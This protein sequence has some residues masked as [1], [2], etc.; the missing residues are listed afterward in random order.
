ME[1][2]EGNVRNERPRAMK[3]RARNQKGHHPV[4][5]SLSKD[6]RDAQRKKR[7]T[8][9]VWLKPGGR[10]RWVWKAQPC[11]T[12]SASSAK[13]PQSAQRRRGFSLPGVIAEIPQGDPQ[14]QP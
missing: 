10:V 4:E 5:A 12:A 14:M 13:G 3:P 6:G 8:G 2:T 1:R 7:Q 9:R 11:H